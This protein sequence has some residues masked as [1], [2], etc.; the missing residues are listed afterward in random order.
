MARPI[1]RLG[2][3]SSHGGRMVSASGFATIDGR[4]VC[5]DMDLHACPLM[6]GPGHPHG[7]T[8]VKSIAALT[9]ISGRRVLVVGSVAGCG[10][11]ALSTQFYVVSD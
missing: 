10:A 5:L 11:Q 7:V 2:D 3:P 6:Y 8:P 4:P 1:V 9:T